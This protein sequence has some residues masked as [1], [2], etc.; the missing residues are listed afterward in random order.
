M[1]SRGLKIYANEKHR[2]CISLSSG[3]GAPTI[4]RVYADMNLSDGKVIPT[5][6]EVFENAAVPVIIGV[7]VIFDNWLLTGYPDAHSNR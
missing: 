1:H 6:F 4:G 5:Q 3:A 2:G 7:D